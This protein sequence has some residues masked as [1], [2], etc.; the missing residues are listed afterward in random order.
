LKEVRKK[1]FESQIGGLFS[2]YLIYLTNISA[3]LA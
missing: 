3:E 2:F 1:A